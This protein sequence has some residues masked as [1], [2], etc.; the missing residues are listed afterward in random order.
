MRHLRVLPSDPPRPDA[1]CDADLDAIAVETACHVP[2]DEMSGDNRV[3]FCGQCRQHVYNIEALPRAEAVR[4][5]AAREGRV[6]VRFHRRRDGTVV[7]AD[8]WARL[9]AARRKGTLAFL[10]MLVVVGV[11]Q[12]FAMAA[13]LTR[14]KNATMGAPPPG[15]GALPA[16]PLL[17]LESRTMGLMAPRSG[18]LLLAPEQALDVRPVSHGDQHRHDRGQR[19]VRRGDAA[20]KG[21]DDRE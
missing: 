8:C 1:A 4:L 7:T 10:G 13:G 11:A 3:R 14:L 16:R 9:R 12:V 17:P 5:I 6:C 21:G 15:R 18:A 2:W 20:V 19:H